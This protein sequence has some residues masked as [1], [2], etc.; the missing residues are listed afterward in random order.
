MNRPNVPL[1][2]YFSPNQQ[3]QNNNE[4]KDYLSYINHCQRVE[5]MFT[6]ASNLNSDFLT[7]KIG[8]ANYVN[9]IPYK[10]FERNTGYTMKHSQYNYYQKDFNDYERLASI[11][12]G[13][14]RSCKSSHLSSTGIKLEDKGNTEE[15]KAINY[16]KEKLV[17]KIEG[18]GE[19]ILSFRDEIQEPTEDKQVLRDEFKEQSP[20]V[21]KR[22]SEEILNNNSVSRTKLS[23]EYFKKYPEFNDD[24]YLDRL[25]FN[26]EKKDLF[27]N[28]IMITKQIAKRKMITEN[29]CKNSI[30]FTF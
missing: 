29:P 20:N 11:M 15:T 25:H 14:N 9:R 6:P 22:S 30:L 19:Q 27:G 5:R 8:R 23:E 21:L 7:E 28:N 2:V 13:N 3:T 1:S 24:E 16:T 4:N 10:L 12:Y 18:N 17:P 26:R